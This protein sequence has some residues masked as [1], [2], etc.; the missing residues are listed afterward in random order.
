MAFA[1]TVLSGVVFDNELSEPLPGVNISIQGTTEGTATDMDG[2]F[3]FSTTKESGVLIITFVGYNAQKVP[4]KGSKNLGRIELTPN[5]ETLGDVVVFGGVIDVADDRK[6][7]VAVS[8][9]RAKEIQDKVGN[10]EFPQVLKNTPSIYV[11]GQAGG[12]GDGAVYVRG[13]DQTNTAFLLNGQP[14]N[15]MEDGNLYWSNWSGM[16]DIAN[17]V[18]VQRGLGSSKLAISSVGGTVNI[19][20]KATEKK[21]GGM[22]RFTAANNNY[23][24]GTVGYN[25][26]MMENGLGLSVMLTHWQGDGYNEGTK[27]AGQS[28][29]LSL[30]Y[31]PNEKHLLNFLIFGAPQYHDQN[32][33]KPISS[34]FSDSVISGDPD[35]QTYNSNWGT[36]NGEYM[37]LRRNYYHKPVANLNWEWNLNDK[38]AL[39]TV[40][41]GSWGRGGGTGPLGNTRATTAD[42]QVDFDAIVANNNDLDP[43]NDGYIRASVNNHSWYGLVTNFEHTLN[44]NWSVNLG[45]DI[46][47]YKG[48]HF[49][50]LVDF[51]EAG[52]YTDTRNVR[53]PGGNVITQ[54][55]KADPYSSLSNYAPVD[56]RYAWDYD[57][58]INYGGVFGQLEY[59]RD[60]FSAFVQG[61]VSSQTHVRW[62]RYQYDEANE[63]SEKVVNPGYNV[64][65]GAALNLDEHHTVFANTGYYSR[66][67]YHDNIYLNFGNDVNPLTENE[68]VLGF[69]AG[70]RFRSTYFDLNLNLYRTSWKDRVT[71]TSDEDSTG[72]TYTV[73]SG[74]SQLHQ[75]VEVDF[76]LRATNKLS[77]FGFA[78]IGD[79][80]YNDDVYRRIYNED[81]VLLS[82]TRDTVEGGK[83][84]NAAQTTLGL[85]AK[86]FLIKGLAVDMDYRYYANLYANEVEK[87]NLK[88]PSYGILDA[89]VSYTLPLKGKQMLTARANAYNLLNTVYILQSDTSIKPGDADSSGQLYKDIDT[90]NE[91][92]FGNGF[93]WTLSL[94]YNF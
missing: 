59:S 87:E 18:Q 86:Y 34:Y 37:T 76:N 25:T 61:A 74:V 72:I 94:G 24:K 23:L 17:A 45:A 32:F 30:G 19:I 8:T 73:N 63:Q 16:T 4:F 44:E 27:G 3:S 75:G 65:G 38:S 54:S 56:Q 70:Y 69:E 26:G 48:T 13:F 41:Y 53:Y 88:L 46:R 7:P 79:W 52:S 90:A 1:Q 31:K 36:L 77:I 89:G 66:Q 55:F 91:V 5:T 62:D 50:Q 42:G 49:R 57:E 81:R 83:V 20:T 39:S 21:E 82:E 84:G 29:F 43:T 12:Y 33:T 15:G 93:T 80:V 58:Q 60:L 35:Q 22:V 92:Y 6:T 78:S 28:Y 10:Q 9:I 51:L 85:G 14:I 64:K 40:L 2:K 68:K 67:P 47:S 71:T 11:N